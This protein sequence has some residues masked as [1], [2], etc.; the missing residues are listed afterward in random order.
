MPSPTLLKPLRRIVGSRSANRAIISFC[1]CVCFSRRIGV[2]GRFVTNC[3]S[4]HDTTGRQPIAVRTRADFVGFQKPTLRDH[5]L[6][7]AFVN[8][9]NLPVITSNPVRTCHSASPTYERV[10][11]PPAK[12]EPVRVPLSDDGDARQEHVRVFVAWASSLRGL[13][14][15]KHGRTTEKAAFQPAVGR[16]T[17]AADSGS[18]RHAE[19][20]ALL[21]THPA[22]HCQQS[23]RW[24][25][26]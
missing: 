7:L 15:F 9:A 12:P 23:C 1:P 14:S 16:T 3:V 19:R 13:A 10:L 26:K 21:R 8:W 25:C 24:P 2:V 6:E 18:R 17:T 20:L 22:P 5:V 4:G 11:N